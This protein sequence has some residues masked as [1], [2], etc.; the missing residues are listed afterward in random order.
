MTDKNELFPNRKQTRQP[1]I[2]EWQVGPE[3][4]THKLLKESK[5]GT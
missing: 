1:A 3:E 2:P 5:T 4:W